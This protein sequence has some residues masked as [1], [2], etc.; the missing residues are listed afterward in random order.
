MIGVGEAV[1]HQDMLC[2]SDLAAGRQAVVVAVTGGR[3]ATARLLALGLAPGRCVRVVMNDRFGPV[4][5]ATDSGS[6]RLAVGRG[7]ALKI[8]L[9]EEAD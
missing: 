9:R 2:L 5:L 4:I 6:T 1:G 3:G 7:L 8:R